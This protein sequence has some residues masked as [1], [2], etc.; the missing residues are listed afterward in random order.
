MFSLFNNKSKIEVNQN[1]KYVYVSK[2]DCRVPIGITHRYSHSNDKGWRY[3]S[4]L[5]SMQGQWR[6][7]EGRGEEGRSTLVKRKGQ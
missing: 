3:S 4:A 1:V 6:G 5:V 7:R 2:H